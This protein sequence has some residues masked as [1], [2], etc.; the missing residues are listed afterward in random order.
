MSRLTPIL[1][2]SPSPRFAEAGPSV[3]QRRA[4]RAVVAPVDAP[5][6]TPLRVLVVVPHELDRRALVA[7]IDSDAGLRVVGAF[8]ELSE[9]GAS[10]EAG[11]HAWAADAAP[12]VVLLQMPLR[13]SRPGGLHA[14]RRRWPGVPLL[15][16]APHTTAECAWLRAPAAARAAEDEREMPPPDLDCLTHAVLNG[17]AGVLRRTATPGEFVAALRRVAAGGTWLDD[18]TARRLVERARLGGH[19]PGELL[20]P[21]ER[22]VARQIAAGHSNKEAAAALEV[23]ESTIKKQVGHLLHKLHRSDRLQLGLFLAQHGY[24]IEEPTGAESALPKPAPAA[25]PPR[26][27]R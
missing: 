11:A 1:R 4:R 7:L 22:R 9:L 25:R 14:L 19:P 17:A 10:D 18:D 5:G 23:S 16:L 12:Q 26:R 2:A 13:P 20:T 15:V 24:L 21:H 3:E 27:P 8:G 6:A